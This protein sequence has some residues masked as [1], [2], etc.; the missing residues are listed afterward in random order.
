M[1]ILCLSFV[2][3]SW[4]L[5]D[6]AMA[7]PSVPSLP[8]DT[9]GVN[10]KPKPSQEATPPLTA[11]DAPMPVTP[12][13]DA[14]TS[15]G[16]ASAGPLPSASLVPNA[17]L[18]SDIE[19]FSELLHRRL[20]SLYPQTSVYH[21]GIERTVPAMGS[22]L[23]GMGPGVGGMSAGGQRRFRGA[24][25]EMGMMEDGNGVM[26]AMHGD[27][28]TITG[29]DFSAGSG[30][31]TAPPQP[32]VS[33]PQF[34]PYAGRV[35]SFRVTL[36][37]PV[38]PTPTAA[39][40]ETPAENQC[41]FRE[42]DEWSQTR[43]QF[44]HRR[45]HAAGHKCSD[46]H[47]GEIQK[48]DNKHITDPKMKNCKGCHDMAALGRLFNADRPVKIKST[49]T[50]DRTRPLAVK[51]IGPTKAELQQT[52]LKLLAEN[53]KHFDIPADCRLSVVLNFEQPKAVTALPG[54]GG[55]QNPGM[56][57][58][59]EFGYGIDNPSDAGGGTPGGAASERGTG[60]GATY[61][62]EGGDLAQ[63]DSSGF[64][65]EGGAS[66]A[67]ADASAPGGF[68]F[69]GGGDFDA[70]GFGE[71]VADESGSA[72]DSFESGSS[73]LGPGG[74]FGGPG[75]GLP[76]KQDSP[77]A[78]KEELIGDLQLRQGQ[79]AAAVNSFEQARKKASADL[80]RL[81]K[82][83]RDPQDPW[84]VQER[85]V[86]VRVL[87]KLA[88]AQLG[89]G[90][91]A[92]AQKTMKSLEPYAKIPELAP[93][94]FPAA[95]RGALH[96]HTLEV[97][98][99]KREMD[100]VAEALKDQLPFVGTSR[101]VAI[102]QEFAEIA[103]IHEFDSQPPQKES[104]AVGQVIRIDQAAQK[105]EISLGADD[106]LRVG[107]R[108]HNVVSGGPNGTWG[109]VEFEVI[110]VAADSA[111][112]RIVKGQPRQNM[113][114]RPDQDPAATPLGSPG[115]FNFSIGIQR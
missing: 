115:T 39:E 98:A 4:L 81:A 32:I 46:C 63:G 74:D 65:L 7:Q 23:P 44:V 8:P 77:H 17:R 102:I 20:L 82:Q 15:E 105:V 3:L 61:E 85:K 101:E 70:G 11:D 41:G 109:P 83:G 89:Q 26:D 45:V 28:G 29:F 67:G 93:T 34:T 108:L 57:A 48:P 113:P 27:Y 14:S 62:S 71:A 104:R 12:P 10:N 40:T 96:V 51:R 37:E 88:Q 56:G 18:L 55:R 16:S 94:A 35:L 49:K 60:S 84:V 22:E 76:A 33:K 24:G 68:G 114:V 52:L 47:L 31:A 21:G 64:D 43:F 38:T 66:A 50:P 30:R 9:N 78:S 25:M 100:A 92:A 86:Y 111:V 79:F 110:T 53:G 42:M 13:L 87:R 1:R 5:V 72:F 54:I 90:E 58:A 36:P 91:I 103:Q 107:Q 19:V 73:A 2:V 106:G 95:P 6:S 69:E 80:A 99:S 75:V 59:S 112:C 97:S